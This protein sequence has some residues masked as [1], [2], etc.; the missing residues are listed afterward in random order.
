MTEAEWSADWIEVMVTGF[1]TTQHELGSAAG[2][3]GRL[4]IPTFKK[5]SIFQG[6]DGRELTMRQPSIWKQ[7]YELRAGEELLGRAWAA[8]LLRRDVVV[9]LHN[10]EYSLQP[11]SFWNRAWRL[12]D[13]QGAVL[14]HIE[15]RGIFRRG[16]RL[17]I[18]TEIELALLAWAYYL[19]HKRWETEAAA[20]HAAASCY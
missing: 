10:Q 9:Q 19:V 11:V 4:T 6:T 14:L 5:T 13:A 2:P 15:P 20:A 18:L 7:V 16:A 1:F 8:G 12:V 17:Q 3:L